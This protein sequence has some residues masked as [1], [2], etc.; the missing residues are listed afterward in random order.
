M[1]SG[2]ISAWDVDRIS[3]TVWGDEGEEICMQ[4]ML[5]WCPGCLLPTGHRT[6]V[7]HDSNISCLCNAL[8]V[9]KENYM[10]S[11]SVCWGMGWGGRDVG[12]AEI[13]LAL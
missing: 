5:P 11:G 6:E 8:E 7:G 10:K 1:G 3:I 2:F 12:R 9:Y 13:A 4:H